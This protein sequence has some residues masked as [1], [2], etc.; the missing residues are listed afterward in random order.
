MTFELQI[1]T[2]KELTVK[3]FDGLY[4]LVFLNGA[5]DRGNLRTFIENYDR[6]AKKYNF[7][8]DKDIVLQNSW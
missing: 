2:K 1:S 7:A 4:N 6:V 5:P 3:L 8:R